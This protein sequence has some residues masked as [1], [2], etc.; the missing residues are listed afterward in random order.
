[1]LRSHSP[2][3]PGYIS[4]KYEVIARGSSKKLSGDSTP[5]APSPKSTWKLAPHLRVPPGALA[6]PHTEDTMSTIE[7]AEPASDTNPTEPTIPPTLRSRLPPNFGHYP[8]D[9][10]II[11][12]KGGC[13]CWKFGYEFMYPALDVAKPTSCNCSWCTRTGALHW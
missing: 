8:P 3:R 7:P 12:H 5:G 6:Y 4:G 2:S 13:H 9:A 11:T 1:M 10:E